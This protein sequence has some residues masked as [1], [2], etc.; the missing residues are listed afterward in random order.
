MES[1]P[2]SPLPCPS[3]FL[4]SSH[5]HPTSTHQPLDRHVLELFLFT[6]SVF[7]LRGD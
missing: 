4:P 3:L 1:L 6:S 5:S 2:T 7:P